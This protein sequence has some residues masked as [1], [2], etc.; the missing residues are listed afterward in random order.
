LLGSSVA[1]GSTVAPQSGV[2][3][4]DLARLTVPRP[5]GANPSNPQSRSGISNP[6]DRTVP[7][8]INPQDMTR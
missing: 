3:Q 5:L 8:A 7:R 6:Q 2:G 1:S 4:R